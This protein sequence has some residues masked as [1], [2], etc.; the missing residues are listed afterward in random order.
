MAPLPVEAL[1]L[2]SE[3]VGLLHSLGVYQVGQLARLSRQDLAARFG[4]GPAARLDQALGLLPEPIRACGEPPELRAEW[5]L[6]YPAARREAVEAVVEQLVGQLAARLL[7]H[8]RGALR[9]ECRLDCQTG[10]AVN[11][12][13]GLYQA[14]A[15]AAHLAGLVR[16]QLERARLPAPV[17]AVRVEAAISAPLEHRQQSLFDDELA[18]RRQ[19]LAG[20]IDRLASRLGPR[21]VLR[22]RLVADAQP[23][24]AVCYDNLQSLSPPSALRPPRSPRPTSH[25]PRSTPSAPRSTPHELPPRPLR[26]LARPAALVA[27]SVLPEGPPVQFQFAGLRRRVARVWGPERIETGWWRGQ[28]VGRDY[29]RVETSAG[30]RFWLFRRLR[31]GKWF[32]HGM[33]E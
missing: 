2:S 21:S 20:L 16:M 11:L 6:E 22:A 26:L 4:P 3:T 33:F 9:L 7:R 8:G 24:L 18:R 14:T 17:T 19:D 27:T 10:P 25:A 5:S 23:E 28:T 31:D 12:A 32:L 30:R 15:S 29:Y 1:R 13:V